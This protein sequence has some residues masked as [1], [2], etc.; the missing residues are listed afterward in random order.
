[1]EAGNR[2]PEAG[3]FRWL[4]CR[5][6]GD[7]CGVVCDAKGW[8]RWGECCGLQ[9]L[10]GGLRGLLVVRYLLYALLD[11]FP[12]HDGVAVPLPVA[13]TVPPSPIQVLGPLGQ[14]LSGSLPLRCPAALDSQFLIV[15][16]L[17]THTNADN[18]LP[19]FIPYSSTRPA[20]SS[21]L[22]PSPTSPRSRTYAPP[23]VRT[24]LANCSSSIRTIC[25][26]GTTT[27][28]R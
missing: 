26:P 9:G 7:M 8:L 21:T 23:P 11:G 3:S 24:W 25:A 10:G 1:M 4:F 18:P 12:G 20:I 28:P 6:V 14:Q 19:S 13:V 27:R 2:K 22:L 17:E 16:L 5:V 15:S